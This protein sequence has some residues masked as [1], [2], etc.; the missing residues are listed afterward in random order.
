M[1]CIKSVV[2][3]IDRLWNCIAPEVK[4]FAKIGKNM[5]HL[6]SQ[7]QELTALRDDLQREVDRAI[8]ERKVPTNE[9]QVWLSQAKKIIENKGK[10]EE[11]FQQSKK[12]FYGWCLDCP[13]L[14]KLG[15]RIVEATRD[16]R[17]HG[18][19]KKK[20]GG[21]AVLPLR[22]P[23]R[24]LDRVWN[25]IMD[26]KTRIIVISG[27]G[28]VGKTN[29]VKNIH[30]R[31]RE[32]RHFEVVIFVTVSRDWNIKKLRNDIG[33]EMRLDLSAEQDETQAS[34]LL[35]N[36]LKGKKFLLILDDM[37]EKVDLKKLGVPSPK[38]N[39]GSKI[40][41][42][43]RNRGVCN[44]ME[45]D[46]EIMVEVERKYRVDGVAALHLDRVLKWLM[47]AKTGIIGIWGKGGVGKTNLVKNIH[48]IIRENGHFEVVIF[49]T[50]SR[51]WNIKELR[52]DIGK[53]MDLPAEEDE[54]R[55]SRLLFNKLKGKKFI[56]ILDDMWEKV[57]LEKLGVPSPKEN[58][59]SKIVITTRN[60]GVCNDMETDEEIMVEVLSDTEAWELFQEKAGSM[61]SSDLEPIARDVCKEC[62]GL[63]L[64]I[65]VVGRAL[66]KET[67]REVWKNALRVLRTSQFELHGMEHQV[68]L[69]LKFSYDH[70]ETDILRD[71]FLYCSLFPEDYHID[72]DDLIAY[73][74][75][76][77]FIEG[78]QSLEDA[79]AKGNSSL[80]ELVDSCLLEKDEY[81]E[82]AVRMHDVIRDMA[83]KITSG[84]TERGRRFLVRAGLG[85]K[86]CPE[87][88]KWEEKDRISLMENDIQSLPDEPKCTELSTLLLQGNELLQEIPQSFFKQ[89]KNLRVLD[90]SRTGIVSLP[91]SISE[92]GSLQALKLSECYDLES[93][94]HVGGLEQ[95]RFLDLGYTFIKE[96]PREI[97]QLTR[98]CRLDLSH[99]SVL[100]LPP[101]ISE[102]GSLQELILSYCKYLR[103][104][105][106]VGGLKQLQL[107]DLCETRIEELP[108]E[109]G[110]LTRLRRLN[111]SRTERLVN[112]P[113]DV[114]V[115]LSLLEDLEMLESSYFMV[116]D[117]REELIENVGHLN[118]LTHFSADI[119]NDLCTS[120][121]WEFLLRDKLK[122][123]HLR[124]GDPDAL[125]S[126][127]MV[128]PERRTR[129]LDIQKPTNV[130][131]EAVGLLQYVEL[132][133]L[134]NHD[135]VRTI[136][137]M[138]A[139]NL[140]RLKECWI[141]DCD[142]ME[143][144]VIAKEA[145][146][147]TLPELEILYLEFL[148]N[149][150]SI[151]EGNET[152]GSFGRIKNITLEGCDNVMHLF[153]S[154]V[155]KLLN[156]LEELNIK[157][158]DEMLEIVTGE[159][160]NGVIALPMLRRI[161]LYKLSKLNRMWEGV[162]S[163]ESLQAIEVTS[164]PSLRQ[165]AIDIEKTPEL[166]VIK[167]EREWWDS[168]E[169]QNDSIKSHFQNKFEHTYIPK[170]IPFFPWG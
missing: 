70:L 104:V 22:E 93:V 10:M 48:N 14:Y 96:L 44:D 105:D 23:V 24:T 100:S 61:I 46:E 74:T 126:W 148:P 33:K 72:V 34:S 5:Y 91:P 8:G 40:V 161:N 92:L 67:N 20:L 85:L 94:T 133:R 73:W 69:H 156:S 88:E 13:S 111:L 112:I 12:C 110:Q 95:L 15:K 77:G 132:L 154:N 65:I 131:Q 157:V 3:I 39:G 49:V 19:R 160:G 7:V 57:D 147:R 142:H 129:C 123:F 17:E 26:Q 36:K 78:V 55:A 134:Y 152:P 75:M 138:G 106:H 125:R 79:S 109:I 31:I 56:L 6:R 102:L 42:T 153:S 130:R 139:R 114:T 128:G 167:G 162:L 64:A 45:I 4:Y 120:S 98:L 37:R 59:G 143:S 9:V 76:E 62:H 158:C 168:L 127:S 11:E 118:Q 165:L 71:C 35:F 83:I 66:R 103:S 150:R 144:V 119:P 155:L 52:H 99:A 84:S 151:W 135:E 89:M 170:P 51:D 117:N 140:K 113:V 145:E 124:F 87:V 169:W 166:E 32:T 18:D 115:S 141:S 68:Y 116:G 122:S 121:Q 81:E 2:D 149:L 163:L 97:G 82:N 164:C 90:L 53:E 80:K 38:E 27:K 58:G 136:S 28:G 1:D 137:A 29:L 30:G 47:D 43:T 107:L 108:R 41:I 60:R 159:V 54:T 63:P 86:E 16:A 101:S 146:E 21:V 25:C 50:V